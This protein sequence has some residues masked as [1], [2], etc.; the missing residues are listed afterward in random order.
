MKSTIYTKDYIVY[1]DYT[2]RPF[3]NKYIV[4]RDHKPPAL[5]QELE[6]ALKYI[7]FTVGSIYEEKYKDNNES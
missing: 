7:G 2:V 6:N 5:F 1:K 4:T 3:G